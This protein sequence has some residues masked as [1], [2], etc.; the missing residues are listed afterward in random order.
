MGNKPTQNSPT[1][2]LL[3]E[4]RPGQVLTSAG[5]RNRGI[6]NR[7]ASYLKASGT[8]ASI[9]EGAYRKATETPPWTAGV[10]AMERELNMPVHVGGKTALELRGV[11]QYAALGQHP[12][13]WLFGQG[14]TKLPKWFL[15]YSWDAKVRLVQTQLFQERGLGISEFKTVEGF[16]ILASRR[17]RAVLEAIHLIGKDHR[18]E[19]IAELFD[20]LAT[21][22]PEMLQTL[23][24]SCQSFKVRRVFLYLS[25]E[26]GHDWFA[27]L[28]E[29]KIDCGKGKR[30]VVKGGALDTRYNIT[31]P[32]KAE[33]PD[34]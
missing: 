16:Q 7:L 31:V 20:G 3:M 28:D 23:L 29:S 27:R 10:E 26:S 14:R 5:M 13:V 18:F 6:S 4:W 32:R 30:E 2:K 19:E 25:R 9:G 17:E 21:L 11:A 8:L 34:V 1:K 24:E 33:V 15:D 12:P 22:D